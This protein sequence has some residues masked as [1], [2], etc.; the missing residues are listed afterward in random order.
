LNIKT[1]KLTLIGLPLSINCS[2]D[3][4]LLSDFE[5]KQLFY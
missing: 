2:H 1:L 5:V 3:V 4:Y